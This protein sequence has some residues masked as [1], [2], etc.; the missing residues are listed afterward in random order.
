[1]KRGRISRRVVNRWRH[2]N[3]LMQDQA[4][5]D[6]KAL[7][8]VPFKVRYRPTL[9]PVKDFQFVGNK[10]IHKSRLF[11]VYRPNC[12]V[13]EI[14]TREH[15]RGHGQTDNLESSYVEWLRWKDK[16]WLDAAHLTT[17]MN[18]PSIRII[19]QRSGTQNDDSLIY[20]ILLPDDRSQPVSLCKHAGC[21]CQLAA[22]WHACGIAEAWMAFST[23][24]YQRHRRTSCI[25]LLLWFYHREYPLNK[26]QLII[27]KKY[28]FSFTHRNQKIMN[29]QK[30][31]ITYKMLSLSFI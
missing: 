3:D 1:M 24:W 11:C 26:L 19:S 22:V 18:T 2:S 16:E 12:I 28:L 4:G 29:N 30:K 17:G 6:H 15:I 14:I 23:V 5:L 8:Q 10:I 25:N 13:E 20:A 31:Q 21:S 7:R 9:P 27:F